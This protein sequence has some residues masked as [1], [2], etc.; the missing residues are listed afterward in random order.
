MLFNSTFWGWVTGQQ[1]LED[2]A[3]S[4]GWTGDPASDF[5][6]VMQAVLTF[7]LFAVVF[8]VAMASIAVRAKREK[9]QKL[10]QRNLSIDEHSIV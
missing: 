1:S 5:K 8:A 6:K 9:K 3:A 7:G 4:V 2:V 10:N